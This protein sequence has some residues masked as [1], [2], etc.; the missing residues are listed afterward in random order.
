[1][2]KSAILSFLTLCLLTFSVAHPAEA[3]MIRK[4][5]TV[6]VE[7]SEKVHPGMRPD[8][9]HRVL[10]AHP[11][12]ADSATKNGKRYWVEVYNTNSWKEFGV[13]YRVKKSG[14]TVVMTAWKNLI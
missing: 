2:L 14:R 13:V 6:T 9:V 1:M 12:F 8:R 10:K 3:A 11:L 5:I 7:E 4:D